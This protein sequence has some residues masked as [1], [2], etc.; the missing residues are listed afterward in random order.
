MS[1]GEP[2]SGDWWHGSN[3]DRK[4]HYIGGYK[5]GEMLRAA[6]DWVEANQVSVRSVVFSCGVWNSLNIY[7]I[8]PLGG[9]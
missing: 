2:L 5:V 6:A 9:E 3:T 4:C 1:E 8:E 7:Y